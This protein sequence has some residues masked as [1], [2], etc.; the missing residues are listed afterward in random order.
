MKLCAIAALAMLAACSVDAA[1]APA[2]AAEPRIPHPDDPDWTVL[3]A[4]F[5]RPDGTLTAGVAANV[6][7][8]S[9]VNAGNALPP[10]EE[11]PA[12]TIGE[13]NGM[14]A[15]SVAG[16]YDFDGV[17]D[18]AAK[19]NTVHSTY[20]SCDGG[21]GVLDGI[22]IVRAETDVAFVVLA[23]SITANG[24]TNRV[25]FTAQKA[26]NDSLVASKVDDGWVTLNRATG[27][28]RD[29]VG[30]WTCTSSNVA[31]TCVSPEGR[32]TIVA[33]K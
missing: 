4:R 14:C 24:A 22:E 29:R 5:A 13:K 8:P 6:L 10:G 12:L 3:R 15:C 7:R 11:C 20:H 33:P 9:P 25:D 19:T 16:S 26:G 32:P 23:L 1:P 17:F 31:Y 18:A 27:V 2:P 21:A 30:T 28:I